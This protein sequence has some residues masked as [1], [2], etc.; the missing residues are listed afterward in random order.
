MDIHVFRTRSGN[1]VYEFLGLN[2]H[3]V[4]IQR[5]ARP[6]FQQVQN[7]EPKRNIGNKNTVHD[8]KVYPI[9]FA[10]IQHFDI[11]FKI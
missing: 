8:I 5:L 3:Q 6:F 4:H 2:N 9:G 11:F 7:R 10:P 1:F